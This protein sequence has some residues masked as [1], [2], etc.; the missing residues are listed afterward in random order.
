MDGVAV[1]LKAAEE[2]EGEE[3]DE[4]ADQRQ[5]DADPGDDIQKHFVNR[6]CVLQSQI[7][8]RWS[9]AVERQEKTQ[10]T[11]KMKPAFYPFNNPSFYFHYC[12]G[13]LSAFAQ[14]SNKL[15]HTSHRWQI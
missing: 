8:K 5:E 11:V 15:L 13:G 7:S 3:A 4:Q 12:F 1:A 6:V 9:A 10:K 14:L 2:T